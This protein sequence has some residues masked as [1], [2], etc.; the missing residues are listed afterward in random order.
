MSRVKG[1]DGIDTFNF[2][3]KTILEH[4]ACSSGVIDVQRIVD[5]LLTKTKDASCIFN[6]TLV[7]DKGMLQFYSDMVKSAGG[8]KFRE[9]LFRIIDLSKT[10][11]EIKY[12]AS[13]AITILNAAQIN[14][15]KQKW[16][17]IRIP[18]ANLYKAFLNYTDLSGADLTNVNLTSAYLKNCSFENAIMKDV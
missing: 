5:G 1:K 14:L 17:G 18:E 3:H 11:S 15:S 16:S 13:N 10:V 12:A 8:Q 2:I 7:I 4:F 9:N 6:D